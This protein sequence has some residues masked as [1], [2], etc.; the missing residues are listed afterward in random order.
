[1]QIN[2]KF[3]DDADQ[4][5]PKA[6]TSVMIK[7][8][9]PDLHMLFCYFTNMYDLAS[10]NHYL[11]F[12]NISFQELYLLVYIFKNKLNSLSIRMQ[13][14]GPFP[15][16]E[17]F[18]PAGNLLRNLLCLRGFLLEEPGSKF[19]SGTVVLSTKRVPGPRSA[20]L[21]SQI[22]TNQAFSKTCC[23]WGLFC[24]PQKSQGTKLIQ[25]RSGRPTVKCV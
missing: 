8:L 16:Q 1:M 3:E 24:L 17:L 25:F 12:Y 5:N 20:L 13:F 11:Y 15:L 4:T 23:T 9:S 14:E 10:T 7:C 18:P 2:F 21:I 19:S 6:L 22:P